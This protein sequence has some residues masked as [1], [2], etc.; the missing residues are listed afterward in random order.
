MRV[1]KFLKEYNIEFRTLHSFLH[2]HSGRKYSEFTLNTNL[3]FDEMEL[4][5]VKFGKDRVA[6][7][8]KENVKL[9]KLL[10]LKSGKKPNEAVV[11]SVPSNEKVKPKRSK[12]AISLNSKFK[13][14][15]EKKEYI[16]RKKKKKSPF[17]K[18]VRGGEAV[19]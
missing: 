9:T 17:I 5:K 12:K 2:D 13:G 16:K 4:A 18:I 11:I 8:K 6:R 7:L 19:N 14:R 3:T 1:G 10:K 15:Q